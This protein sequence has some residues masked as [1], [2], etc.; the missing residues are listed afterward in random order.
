MRNK[1]LLFF[2]III[3]P[4]WVTAQT[5]QGYVKTKGRMINGEYVPG[6]GL[7][8]ASVSIKGKTTILVNADNGFFSFHVT[9]QQFQLDSVKKEGYQLVDMDACSKSYKYSSSPIYIVME[10]PE[11]QLQDQLDA[12]RKIRRNL[13]KQLQTKEDELEKLMKAKKISSK[14]YQNALQQLYAKQE[15]NEKLITDMAKRYAEL[16][17]DQLDEFY[18]QVSNHIEN[19]ELVKADSLLKT[20]GDISQQVSVIRQHGQ[21]LNEKKV[22]L[23]E[24]EAVQ[25]ADI[26]EAA[27]RCY[28]YFET[29]VAQSLIDTAA[30]YLELR[31]SLDTTNLEWVNFA[32]RF[33]HDYVGNYV[34]ALSYYQLVLRN[35]REEY[36]ENSDWV[37][38][39]YSNIGSAY[40]SMGNFEQSLNYD[41]KAFVIRVALFGPNHPDVA[42]SYNNMAWNSMKQGQYEKALEYYNH[43]LRILMHN[44]GENHPWVA[45]CYFNIGQTYYAQEEYDKAAEYHLKA[46]TLRQALLP[47]NHPD[48]AYS[49]N[50]V[51]N[52]CLDLGQ[53]DTALIYLDTALSI[54][55]A[56]Y[57]DNH[58]MVLRCQGNIGSAYMLKGTTLG[59]QGDLNA[60]LDNLNRALPLLK[61][62]YGDDNEIV[63]Q[64]QQ[65]IGK[66][67]S[68]NQQK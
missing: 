27:Q 30:Y 56:A 23:Q 66:M 37:A 25:R 47:P 45:T 14:E 65:I 38:V 55:S 39:C 26:H 34:K 63:I 52:L 35:A 64:L 57:S 2:I 3:M 31:A 48:L 54:W 51:G 24:A 53:Y 50:D 9:E 22:L 10:T 20:K 62:A 15:N 4:F 40:A 17:Y 61:T 19:G 7:K 41:N 58:P 59:Q 6:Q 21:V 11:Q 36:G 16:D 8:G 13:Q 32:G 49:Y 29:F 46:L 12:E 5:Q 28:S 44:Y 43:A 33:I 60:S 68:I 67:Q 1:L 42:T 18:R